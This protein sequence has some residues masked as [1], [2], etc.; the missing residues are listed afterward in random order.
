MVRRERRRR[1]VEGG[2]KER[3]EKRGWRPELSQ[4]EEKVQ[5]QEGGEEKREEQVE[6]E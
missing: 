3:D 6:E 2:Q 4:V 1:K 5:R